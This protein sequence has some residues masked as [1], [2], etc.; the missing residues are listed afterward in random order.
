M[1][2]CLSHFIKETPDTVV[3]T[4]PYLSPC[5]SRAAIRQIIQVNSPSDM[6]VLGQ[7]IERCCWRG[8]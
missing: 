4:F 1:G 8:V 7:T 6:Q 2:M 3:P 5:S